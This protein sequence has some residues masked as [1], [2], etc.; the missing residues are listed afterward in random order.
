MSELM[1]ALENLIQLERVLN[2][3]QTLSKIY[4]GGAGSMFTMSSMGGQTVGKAASIVTFSVSPAESKNGEKV[5][6]DDLLLTINKKLPS[7]Q[8]CS[9]KI[10]QEVGTDLH[11]TTFINR[12]VN[13]SFILYFVYTLFFLY[14]LY[15]LSDLICLAWSK[16]DTT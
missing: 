15:F 12:D 13:L 8:V 3:F 4:R 7:V 10:I 11:R 16:T 6:E 9:F 5:V 14:I 2:D 1:E